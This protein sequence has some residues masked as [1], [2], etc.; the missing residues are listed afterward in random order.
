MATPAERQRKCR[1]KKFADPDY[2]HERTK[3]LERERIKQIRSKQSSDRIEVER[4]KTRI[5]V[6]NYRK[7]KA[8]KE[9]LIECWRE[10]RN[11]G[12]NCHGMWY[13]GTMEGKMLVGRL[14]GGRDNTYRLQNNQ[15]HEITLHLQDIVAGPVDSPEKLQESILQQFEIANSLDRNKVYSS[16]F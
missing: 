8:T 1:E 6:Q 3:E 9:A 4:E 16:F 13:V 2:N 12:G 14:V 15:E 5:R 7:R 11:S 10:I